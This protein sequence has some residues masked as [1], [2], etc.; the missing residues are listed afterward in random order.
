MSKKNITKSIAWSHVWYYYWG[1][2]C[3]R[4]WRTIE[5]QAGQYRPV[6][7]RAVQNGQ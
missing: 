4:K 1:Q 6:P 7:V 2:P 3:S 5:R